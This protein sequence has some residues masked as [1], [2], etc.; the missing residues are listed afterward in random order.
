MREESAFS[1]EVWSGRRA[2]LNRS[3]LENRTQQEDSQE[4]STVISNTTSKTA[5]T[6]GVRIKSHVKAGGISMQHNQAA[7]DLRVKSRVKAGSYIKKH[8]GN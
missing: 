2:R 8:I 6:S 4:G 5:A 1:F 7:K 3:A